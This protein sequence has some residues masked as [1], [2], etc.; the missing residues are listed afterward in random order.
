MANIV[1]IDDDPLFCD[2]LSTMLGQDGHRVTAASDGEAG[3]AL[4]QRNPP[5]LVITDILMPRLDGVDII[6]RLHVS[7]PDLPIIAISGGRRSI[8]AE[9]NLNSATLIGARKTL[10]K[11]F[12]RQQLLQTVKE[13]LG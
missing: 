7:H 8:S 4:V 12:T 2:L 11:P 5:D 6:R 13:V 10:A 1:V 9:F 3:L